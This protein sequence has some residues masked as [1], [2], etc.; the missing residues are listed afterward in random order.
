VDQ[1]KLKT[2]IANGGKALIFPRKPGEFLGFSITAGVVSRA[3]AVPDWSACRGL[4]LSDFY[5]KTDFAGNLLTGGTAGVG[6]NGVL[7]RYQSGKGEAVILQ[8]VPDMLNAAKYDY[9]RYASWRLTRAVSQ[10]LTNL[11]ADFAADDQF[12]VPRTT[13][14]TVREI[15]LPLE[16]KAEFELKVDGTNSKN[17]RLT[18][19]VNRGL[20]EG[21]HQPDF[22]GDDRVAHLGKIVQACCL[23]S[24]VGWWLDHA[25]CS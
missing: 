14:N 9:Y 11:G 7:G 17:A 24:E 10:L 2:F 12:F 25:E 15:P 18:D 1:E 19:T 13:D 6:L 5:L 3:G 8:L 23:F 21:W 16:W 22:D 4:S 20:Q